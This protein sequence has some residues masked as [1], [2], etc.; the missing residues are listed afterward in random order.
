MPRRTRSPKA[1]Q[2]RA[3]NERE[4][5]DGE[6]R[7]LSPGGGDPIVAA[8]AGTRIPPPAALTGANESGE[9]PTPAS[10]PGKMLVPVDEWR[11][12][13]SEC[14]GSLRASSHH[15][16][17]CCGSHCRAICPRPD[18]LAHRYVARRRGRSRPVRLLRRQLCA[19]SGVAMLLA[20]PGPATTN[21]M[22]YV[23]R[24]A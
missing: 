13:G 23:A 15:S 20:Y 10:V 4:T 2:R 21:T 17:R 12:E 11:P 14:S 24:K 5:S 7:V 9:S 18:A 6:C 8:V 19:E 1:T 16:K 22:R 3:R